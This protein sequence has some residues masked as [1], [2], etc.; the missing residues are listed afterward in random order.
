MQGIQRS[1]YHKFDL[2]KSK[3]SLTPNPL[4]EIG[5]ALDFSVLLLQVFGVMET[6]ILPSVS[7]DFGFSFN[8]DKIYSGFLKR[9][10]KTILIPKH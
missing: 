5:L 2:L 7:R 6:T 1:F 9:E 3:L 4:V 8:G 10:N